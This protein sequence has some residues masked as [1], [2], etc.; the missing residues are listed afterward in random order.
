MFCNNCG[1]TVTVYDPPEGY[2]L[3]PESLRYYSSQFDDAGTQWVTWFDANT[4]EYEQYSYPA[5]QPALEP[6]SP[7]DPEPISEP[8]PI[9]EPEPEQPAPQPNV[10]DGFVFDTNSGAYYKAM[11]GNDLATGVAGYWYT[12]FY[13]E[14]G[15][16][17]QQFYPN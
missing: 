8:Q 6:E 9:P 14:T 1:N 5:E 7:S 4:G 13:P 3:D 15:E 16:Y 17:Q 2:V 10:P 11:P 12:W